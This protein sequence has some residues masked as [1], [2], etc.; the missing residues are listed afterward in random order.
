VQRLYDLGARHIW[1]SGLAPL[2]CIP[3][4]RVLSDTG[5]DCLEEV[6]EYAIAFNAA[7][8]ELLEGL[9]AKLP[10]ARMVLADTYSIVMDLIDHPYKYGTS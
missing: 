9:V 3:S 8:A 10:G 1:F 5:K 4:Q 7:A 6:N 2:G